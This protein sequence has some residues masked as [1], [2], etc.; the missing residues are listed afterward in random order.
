MSTAPAPIPTYL[1]LGVS[2]PDLTHFLPQNFRNQLRPD[3]VLRDAGLLSTSGQPNS[4]SEILYRSHFLEHVARFQR[5]FNH[6][7]TVI[8]H[9]LR[10]GQDLIRHPSNTTSE[11]VLDLQ[12]DLIKYEEVSNSSREKDTSPSG[13]IGSRT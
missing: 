8:N 4:S 5:P 9:Q 2:I 12:R 7:S 13:D 10:G 3:I 1:G 6:L 11:K